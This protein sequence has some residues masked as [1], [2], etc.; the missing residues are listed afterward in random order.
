MGKNL[1]SCLEKR[2]L[3]NRPAVSVDELLEWGRYYE[4]AG[5]VYD[6]VDFYEKAGASERLEKWAT[7]AVQDGD[8]FLL[9]R[10]AG[11]ADLK[12]DPADWASLAKR[13]EVLGKTVYA[14]VA[15]REA[16]L[17]VDEDAVGSAGESR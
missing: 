15:R 14:E 4:E 16:G 13:A 9:R 3:L 8:A 7:V 12:P 6:A 5:L 10:I 11:A 2:D 1:L 17:S